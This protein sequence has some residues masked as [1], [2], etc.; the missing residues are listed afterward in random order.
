MAVLLETTLGDLVIDLFTKERPNSSLNFLKLCKM[1]YYNLCQFHS[2]EQNYV[3]QTG[4]PS[5]TGRG[6]ESIFTFV[7]G[8]Q[9][10]FFEKEDLPKMKHTRIG[11]VSFVNNGS[12]MLGSQF[13]I[14][15]GDGL[16]YLDD[17]HTIFG[18]VT[19]GL[20][21]LEKLNQELCDNEHKPYK[22]IR[23]AH[24][25]VLHDPFEDLPKLRFPSRSPSPTLELLVTVSSYQNIIYC[26]FLLF[27]KL[28]F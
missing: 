8:D 14:T 23:I 26:F 13:F 27:F 21:T 19:E 16:D 18:Q 2:I 22:D 9:A 4:D 17:K 3:A 11:I 12:N 6:G 15:L 24:T 20:D 5:G 7:Y 25:I 28:L 1:K 10:R